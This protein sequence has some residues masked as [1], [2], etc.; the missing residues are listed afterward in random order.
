M[1]KREGRE[2]EKYREREGEDKGKKE[3]EN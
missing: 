2:E 3:I 1:I